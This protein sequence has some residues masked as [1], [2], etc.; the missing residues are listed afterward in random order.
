[1]PPI[2]ARKD[3]ADKRRNSP[4]RKKKRQGQDLAFKDSRDQSPHGQATSA[5]LTQGNQGEPQSPE[6]EEEHEVDYLA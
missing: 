2:S 1:M 6:S 3:A 5:D 4:R